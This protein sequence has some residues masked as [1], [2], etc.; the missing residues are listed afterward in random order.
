MCSQAGARIRRPSQSVDAASLAKDRDAVQRRSRP[1]A[2]RAF[3]QSKAR[4]GPSSDGQDAA[5][6][7]RRVAWLVA[8][9][10][11]SCPYIQRPDTSVDNGRDDRYRDDRTAQ[12]VLAEGAVAAEAARR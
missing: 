11:S 12:G 6:R 8:E 4:E 3:P 10:D 1:I 2:E 7:R 5:R 9:V